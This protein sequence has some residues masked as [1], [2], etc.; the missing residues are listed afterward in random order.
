MKLDLYLRLYTKMNSN[1]IKDPNIKGKTIKLLEK[2]TGEKFKHWI[3][4]D[5]L[6][7]IPRTQ[8]TKEK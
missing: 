7:T 3:F 5:F 4:S 1:W 6:D 2:N 8:A